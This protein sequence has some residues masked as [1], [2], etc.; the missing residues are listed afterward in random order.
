MPLETPKGIDKTFYTL[1]DRGQYLE[2]KTTEKYDIEM[3][4]YDVSKYF[5]R[6]VRLHGI[7]GKMKVVIHA[8]NI[9]Y[10]E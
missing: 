4:I 6:Y 8:D 3:L 5:Q 9:D 1:E 7:K 2:F 10:N